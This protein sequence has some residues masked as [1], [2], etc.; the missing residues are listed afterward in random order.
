VGLVRF[1]G[2]ESQKRAFSYNAGEPKKK[3]AQSGRFEFGGSIE[4][5]GLPPGQ[6]Q[7]KDGQAL[8]RLLAVGASVAR[9][10]TTESDEIV[11]PSELW[12][13]RVR[14]VATEAP[15]R[16]VVAIARMMVLRISVRP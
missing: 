9:G 5:R 13:L 2:S 6:G 10:T 14:P 15:A 7:A 11:A 1:L 8:G 3:A 16:K 4:T 12:K